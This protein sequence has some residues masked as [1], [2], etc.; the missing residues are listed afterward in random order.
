MKLIQE[1]KQVLNDIQQ[2]HWNTIILAE[3]E[4]LSKAYDSLS[5]IID[6]IA[7]T[8]VAN[9]GPVLPFTLKVPSHTI[10]ELPQAIFD[11]ATSLRN[12]AE[13]LYPDLVNL[14]DE[15]TAVGSRLKY[16]YRLS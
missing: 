11:A 3:H 8:L 5:P 10:K 12:H 1:F 6:T 4:T 14:A 13:N 7:E 2:H 9:E 16:F 15:V